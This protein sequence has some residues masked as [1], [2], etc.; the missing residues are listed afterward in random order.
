M[1]RP[2]ALTLLIS[3]TTTLSAAPTTTPTTNPTPAP[4]TIHMLVPGGYPVPIG[5]EKFDRTFFADVDTGNLQ[6][7]IG[8]ASPKSSVVFWAYKSLA[9]AAGLFD[10]L[11]AYDYALPNVRHFH[12][13][14]FIPSRLTDGWQISG[15]TTLQTGFP[16]TVGSSVPAS[17]TCNYS[18][19]FYSCWDRPNT[20]APAWMP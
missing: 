5:K 12:P 1:P 4:P 19:E 13:F 2:L 8:A 18:F 14:E 16:V 10:K 17:D 20:V 6:L 11:I 7:V 3:L 15:I 9:G